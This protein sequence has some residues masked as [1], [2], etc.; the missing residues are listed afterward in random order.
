MRFTHALSYIL[1]LF[2]QQSIAWI[3][4]IMSMCSAADGHGGSFQSGATVKRAAKSVHAGVLVRTYVSI[5]WEVDIP[6]GEI[7]GFYGKLT[8]NFLSNLHTKVAVLFYNPI[9]NVGGFQFYLLT[10]TGY[11][12]SFFFFFLFF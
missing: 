2:E 8:F 11:F 12:L 1:T 3:H 9:T 4:H 10:N 5:F 6:K 7:S